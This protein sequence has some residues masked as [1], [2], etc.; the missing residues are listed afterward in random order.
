MNAL[1]YYSISMGCDPEFFFSKDGKIVG[2]EKLIPKEGKVLFERGSL[3]HDTH[4]LTSDSV[5]GKI[6]IDGVQ[7]EL[8]PRPHACRATLGNE[9][10]WCFRKI[11]NELLKDGN[12]IDFSQA[13]EVSKE[14]MDSLSASSK[15][16][17]CSPSHNAY[18]EDGNSK[19]T[20]NPLVYRTRA[21][22]GHIHLGPNPADTLETQRK[23][24]DA[25]D[26]HKIIVPILDLIV[27]NTCVLVDRNPSNIERRKVYGK[28][29]E[30]RTPKYGLEYR[31]LSN[32]WLTSYPL[33][34]M[35]F[36]LARLA[37]NIVANDTEDF[38][39]SKALLEKVRMRDVVKAINENDF[40]LALKNFNAI[41]PLLIEMVSF[42]SYH[43]I[44]TKN[45]AYFE[46]FITKPMSYWFKKNPLDHWIG[47]GDG[48][49]GGFEDFL[50]EVVSKDM[51][52]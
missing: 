10:A 18:A 26:N 2:S 36:G 6:I 40:D 5:F 38:S 25:L 24:K 52:K 45:I 7:A 4:A 23:I 33:F 19:I 22:G 31:T 21:A 49:A 14:E 37:V 28:A 42:G 16:F 13:V 27:G 15:R 39:Y 30:Y 51:I 44:T 43:P 32:F 41:K 11:K 9:I 1:T 17:G 47:L 46:H 20:V 35:A 3:E 8:N 12:T 34:G 48:H 29:G 50:I